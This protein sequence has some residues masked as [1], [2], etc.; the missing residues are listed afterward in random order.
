MSAVRKNLPSTLRN[1]LL[2]AGVIAAI[3]AL[4]ALSAPGNRLCYWRDACGEV[5]FPSSFCA[6]LQT[7]DS[8]SAVYYRLGDP[9]RQGADWAQ[10]RDADSPKLIEATFNDGRLQELR[11]QTG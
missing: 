10:W 8:R 4:A 3:S 9:Y 11:C 2:G 7:G 6:E 1:A 5:K